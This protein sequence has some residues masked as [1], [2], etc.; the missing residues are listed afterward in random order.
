M[1]EPKFYGMDIIQ[2]MKVINQ[3]DLQQTAKQMIGVNIFYAIDSLVAI[4]S[5]N[6]TFSSP[7]FELCIDLL[8]KMSD[9]YYSVTFIL[10]TSMQVA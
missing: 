7:I 6:W 3:S 10:I 4:C 9:I 1:F 5:N 2:L 8:M